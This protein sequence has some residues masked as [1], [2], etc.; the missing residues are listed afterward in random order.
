RHVQVFLLVTENTIE[1]QMLK[2][3]SAKHDLALAAL[4]VGSDVS[5]VMLTSGVEELKRRLEILL[6]SRPAAAVDQSLLQSS[7]IPAQDRDTSTTIQQQQKQIQEQIVHASG[8]VF[9]SLFRFAD[10]LV[11]TLATK[12]E[13]ETLKTSGALEESSTTLNNA[14]MISE[15]ILP[16]IQQAVANTIRVESDAEG[17]TRLSFTIPERPVLEGFLQTAAQLLNSFIAPKQK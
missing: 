16:S 2:T 4:D 9:Q 11:G 8:E 17:K 10:T 14:S 7:T 1:E 3:I 13:T 12:S 15:Q 5:E 6:G